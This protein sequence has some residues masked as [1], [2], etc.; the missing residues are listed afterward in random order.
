M[1]SLKSS[2]LALTI[3]ICGMAATGCQTPLF[4][5]KNSSQKATAPA[6]TAE[7]KADTKFVASELSGDWAII[8]VNGEAVTA[9]EGDYPHM[10]FSPNRDNPGW[11][12]F[13]AYN[14]CNFINGVVALQGSKIAK[15]GD[16][17]ATM[18]LCPDAK[19][20]TGISTALELMKT[21]KIQ[22]INNESFLY[23]VDGNGR[24]VM[25]LRKHNL[26]FLEG[27]WKVTAINGDKLPESVD[28]KIVVDLQTNTVHG[29]AG[30]NVLNGTVEVDM[31]VEN[32][33]GF[34]NLRTTRMTC[35][36]IAYETSFI[37]ALENVRTATGN[38][39]SAQLRDSQGKVIVSMTPLSRN[40]LAAAR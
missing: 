38:A 23:L 14:G 20:E 11:I 21:L 8:D 7:S 30:C 36:N 12:D 15:Q 29:D 3:V 9:P 40:D 24:A 39:S 25:T 22:K 10:S 32:G 1:K 28:I 16:F 31:S 18:K 19:F 27:A 26:N 37:L 17:A 6:T 4:M 13:Y 5:S 33:I 35:P 34:T 2:A